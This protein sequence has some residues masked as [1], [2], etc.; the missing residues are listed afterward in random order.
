[1][2]Q[3]LSLVRRVA[4][5]FVRQTL[6]SLILLPFAAGSA[7][8]L[9][10]VAHVDRDGLRAIHREIRVGESKQAILPL[11]DGNPTLVHLE[12]FEV[13]APDARIVQHTP[14]GDL[15][16]P[17]PKTRF[18]RGGIVGE[19]ESMVFLA[20]EK[21][22]KGLI[23][24]QGHIFNV[25]PDHDLAAVDLQGAQ[26]REIDPDL[27]L[28]PGTAPLKCDLDHLALDH[29]GRK[30][31]QALSM[32]IEP[33]AASATTT[34][35]ARLS[36]DIDDELFAK[37]PISNNTTNAANYVASLVGAANV[38]YARDLKTNLT[39]GLIHTYAGSDPWTVP[40]CVDDGTPQH[41]CVPGTGTSA[42]LAQ[43][44]TYYHNNRAAES[45][46]SAVLLS[47]KNFGGGVAW[48][49]TVCTGD[50]YCGPTGDSCGSLDFANSYGGGYAF[51][52]SVTGTVNTSNPGL[53][54]FWDALAF[55][56]E[57]GHN[58]GSEHTHCIA[59]SA[60]DQATYSR[61]YVDLCYDLE[62][63]C[64][65]GSD[66]LPPE[67]GTI[68]SYCHLLAGG[69]N[70]VRLIFG[71]NG[72][73]SH[74]VAPIMIADIDGHTPALGLITAPASVNASS[75]GNS[76]SIPNPGAGIT[77]LWT[78]TGGTIT[79]GGAT[80]NVTFTAGAS[81]TVVLT[82]AITNASGCGQTDTKTV[83]I[84]SCTAPA[85]ST[86]PQSVAVPAG[87]GVTLSVGATG[88]SLAYQ[89]YIGTSGVTTNPIAGATG[90][91]TNVTPAST[92]TY[93]VRVS[94]SCGT[95]NSAA[96]TVTVTPIAAANFFLLTPCRVLDT[97]GG[98]PVPANGVM[99]LVMTGKCGVPAGATAAAV[100]VTVVSPAVTGLVT[101]YP[102]PANTVKPLV[103]TINYVAGRTLANNARLTIG[104]DGSINIFNAAGTPLD[105]LI[106]VSGYFK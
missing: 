92:T 56:H 37:A 100:N 77:I 91:S 14:T 90:A 75:G 86:Q 65:S 64:W 62:G 97:R 36:I 35:L 69:Y 79:A 28:P 30:A 12:R 6:L 94:N 13:F 2:N 38:I 72:E 82:V 43:L 68:M 16:F 20:V 11:V 103:S 98:T 57:L 54:T 87:T 21:E 22:V 44:G 83:S 4:P 101:L 34:Y 31:I 106:D 61:S 95:L 40:P 66:S 47:G 78:I 32:P 89:W 88:T 45:R 39:I 93:W 67:K 27:D 71:Q 17:I 46:S 73:A 49:G 74:V 52:G 41:N 1:M 26:I 80:T 33:L 24:S 70:N 59:L 60:A 7:F 23:I 63:G 25:E 42:G 50:F 19:S 76:A 81:G 99:N 10:A 48:I 51:I 58:F 5:G 9:P 15:S 29:P 3:M 96:A 8:A 18:Y 104:I 53:S 55:S 102:G 84:V 105:F 85:I